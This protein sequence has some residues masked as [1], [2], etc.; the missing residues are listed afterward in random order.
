MFFF[1]IIALIILAVII[2]WIA[3][4][5]A[6]ATYSSRGYDHGMWYWLLYA[7]FANSGGGSYSGRGGYSSGSWGGGSFGGGV[8]SPAVAEV[9]A[10]AEPGKLVTS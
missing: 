4:A 8:V 1:V 10:A 2:R 3:S 6:Y 9:S 5:H 7:M